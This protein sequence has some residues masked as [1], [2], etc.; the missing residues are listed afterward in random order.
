MSILD[1]IK[2]RLASEE[3][4]INAYITDIKLFKSFVDYLNNGRDSSKGIYLEEDVFSTLVS[5]LKSV[6]EFQKFLDDHS[7]KR[8]GRKKKSVL[9]DPENSDQ[10][11]QSGCYLKESEKNRL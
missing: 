7:R 1:Q 9:D 4:K 11:S 5:Q 8:R 3:V 10:K 6:S 2:P